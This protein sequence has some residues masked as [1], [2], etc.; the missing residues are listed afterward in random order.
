LGR[1]VARLEETYDLIE[2]VGG[3][4]PA[5]YPLNLA[6]AAVKEFTD[7]HDTLAREFG[8]LDGL[9]LNAGILGQRTS[10][11]QTRLEDW[12][13]VMHVNVTANF[14]LVK[15][16]LPL[17]RQSD[18]ASVLFTSSSV[19]RKGRAYWGAYAVSKFATEGL[20]QV[21][22]DELENVSAIRVNAINPGA[23]NTAMRRTAYPAEEPSKNPLPEQIMAPYLYLLGPDS[24]E[25]N[26]VSVD[27]QP[28]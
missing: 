25:V 20:M 6:T 24:G 18:A 13:Q 8:R 1:T 22:A 19:G 2:Q 14:A 17:L 11:E 27:A 3:P 28:R 16:L 10:I 21:L 7:L 26:G 23:T 15:T 5:I 4:Q 12:N 9:L